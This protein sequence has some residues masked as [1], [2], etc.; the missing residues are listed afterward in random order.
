MHL[1]TYPAAEQGALALGERLHDL[2]LTLPGDRAVSLYD[3]RLFG[4]PVVLHLAA[5]PDA[6]AA[7]CAKLNALMDDFLDLEVQIYV[8]TGG[9]ERDN[10]VL[11]ER[12]GLPFPVLRDTEGALIR[13]LRLGQETTAVEGPSTLVFDPILRLE[14]VFDEA[15]VERQCDQALAWLQSRRKALPPAVVTAQPPVLVLPRVLSQKQC[16]GLIRIWETGC[17]TA[18]TVV[19][20]ASGG[21][22][23]SGRKLRTD[24]QLTEDMAECRDLLNTLNRQ[25]LPEVLKGFGFRVTRIETPRIGCYAADQGG[26]FAA[27][28][29][30][31]NRMTE[32]RRFALTINLNSGEYEGGYLRF[33]EF[34]PQLYAPETGGAVVFGC[35][36]LHMV[37]PVTAGRRFALV[38]FFYGEEEEEL[39]QQINTELGLKPI[40]LP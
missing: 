11:G 26:Y 33:P 27:H 38:G 2:P 4:R 28:R 34:G 39:R 15:E 22:V 7:G 8:V 37:T 29:D 1:K 10:G 21:N 14:A 20:Q 17:Q 23:V 6:A 30:N 18:G 16:R 35:S 3:N 12:L 19:S 25:L 24:V 32:Y 5:T 31:T 9:P 36:L 40:T 13:A